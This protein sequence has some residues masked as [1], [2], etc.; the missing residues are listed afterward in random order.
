MNDGGCH[1]VRVRVSDPGHDALHAAIRTAIVMPTALA[2]GEIGVGN[3][4]TALFA[5][6]GS[7]ALLLFAE[8]NG[9]PRVQLV[10]N[11][12]LMLVGA[13]LITIGTLFSQSPALV[14]AAAMAVIGFVVLFAGIVNGYVAAGGNAALLSF[15]LPVMLPGNAASI[16]A[17]LSGWAIGCSLAIAARMFLWPKRAPDP[18]RAAAAD[19]C[20]AL[21]DVVGGAQDRGR[22]DA[23]GAAVHAVLKRYVATPFR[24]TSPT[25]PSG[26]LASL[27]EELPFLSA[28]VV[29]APTE[30]VD[31]DTVRAA[32]V[33]VL[34]ESAAG[35]TG[36][37]GVVNLDRLV[38]ARDDVLDGLVRRLADPR[39]GDDDTVRDALHATWRLQAM[40]NTTLH[41][42]ELARVVAG[43]EPRRA[44]HRLAAV[45]RLVAD[46]VN[47]HSVWLRNALRA[48]AG[49]AAAVFL[50][51]L[52]SFQHAF[53]IV[54]GT[55]FVL[56]SS[57]LRTGAYA[58][59]AIIG[60]TIGIVIGGAV[61]FAI[62][63]NRIVL[64]IV[65][66]AA[67]LLAA[68]APRAISF[69]AGQAGFSVAMVILFNL[70]DPVGWDVGIVRVE[71]VAIGVA[72]SAVVGL[73]FWPRGAAAVLRNRLA[74]AYQAG[75]TYLASS[76]GQLFDRG[77]A[78][79]LTLPRQEAVARERLLDAAIRQFLTERAPPP[80]SADVAMLLAGAVTLRVSGDS[81]AGLTHEVEGTPPPV[82]ARD[83][84]D[85]VEEVSAWYA[86]LGSALAGRVTPPAPATAG[87]E[88][89]T[90]VLVEVRAAAHAGDRAR[91]I[92]AAAA[93]WGWEHLELLRGQE[94]QLVRAAG[95]LGEIEI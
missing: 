18:L 71:D 93:I 26:A 28:L 49:V 39:T 8:F 33:D 56:R 15:I 27:V 94:D 79:R 35:L 91:T 59:Q 92:S 72:I 76:V 51:R 30:G 60:T 6:F 66:P 13:T 77:P 47:L 82:V 36:K 67:V 63:T 87:H 70:I 86:A 22:E 45:R 90:D 25:G 65:L 50:A 42:G 1:A 11:G 85:D 64:W 21:A 5:G 31:A 24:P 32:T 2:I 83:Q 74:E 75:T 7:F 43:G 81:L 73:L 89:P 57:A 69:A 80:D 40:S 84:R 4:D 54:L 78:D 55:L 61:V 37:G 62:G 12:V 14:A 23:A 38:E 19:A 34:R 95:R 88:L 3:A 58:L 9:P 17:R 10:A 41:V 16:P 48:T 46:H 44:D 29:P 68:Y 52:V 53:W 20:R